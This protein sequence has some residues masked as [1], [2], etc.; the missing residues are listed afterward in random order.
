MTVISVER[1]GPDDVTWTFSDP[2]ADPAS[3]ADLRVNGQGPLQV[4]ASTATTLTVRYDAI[5][6]PASWEATSENGEP[7]FGPG[8]QLAPASGA[9]DRYL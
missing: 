5:A 2:V 6:D 3:C 9:L 7:D 8:R 1:A 4:I